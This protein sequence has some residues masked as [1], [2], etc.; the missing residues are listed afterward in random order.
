M[1]KYLIITVWMLL[2]AS[3]VGFTAYASTVTEPPVEDEQYWHDVVNEFG[4]VALSAEDHV[5]RE[6]YEK[7]GVTYWPAEC[8]LVHAAFDEDLKPGDKLIR[9]HGGIYGT[10]VSNVYE[11]DVAEWAVEAG[12]FNEDGSAGPNYDAYEETREDVPYA[13]RSI[14]IRY[15]P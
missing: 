10:V 6:S 14:V 2:I 13:T 15:G 11:I 8:Y 1:K 9:D 3:M 5:C 4:I 12:I 7:D